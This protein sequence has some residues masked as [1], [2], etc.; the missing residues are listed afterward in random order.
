MLLFFD[1]C[2]V[3]D[4]LSK[5]IKDGTL[6]YINEI[7]IE[8]HDWEFKNFRKL[9]KELIKTIQKVH[10]IKHITWK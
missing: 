9:K 5:M 6:G 1:L 2:G 4:C 7:I 10:N 3:L 8:W